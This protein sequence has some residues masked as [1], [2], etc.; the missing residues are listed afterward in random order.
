MFRTRQSSGE[1]AA[2]C[3]RLQLA[4]GG[5]ARG[6]GGRGRDAGFQVCLEDC[7]RPYW[8]GISPLLSPSTFPPPGICLP[9]Q[10]RTST[11]DLVEPQELPSSQHLSISAT[12][13][14]SSP[15]PSSFTSGLL[16]RQG[17][18]GGLAGRPVTFLKLGR[19]PLA[20]VGKHPGRCLV[21]CH[22][23]CKPG[24]LLPSAAAVGMRSA[25]EA[26][27]P[28]ESWVCAAQT[29]AQR[30]WDGLCHDRG[31]PQ[32]RIAAVHILAQI[33]SRPLRREVGTR[34]VSWDV[35]VPVS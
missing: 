18:A 17:Q 25:R 24:D 27:E 15:H 5:T 26:A 11:S 29:T 13:P 12:F 7:E 23:K 20:E 9:M 21:K 33:S 28:W 30:P 31:L 4:A 10:L 3:E 19:L 2:P 1:A 14:S 8:A 22:G 34:A 32:W 35:T 6:G 16:G